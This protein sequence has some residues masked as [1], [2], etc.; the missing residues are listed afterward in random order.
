MLHSRLLRYLDEVAR[1]GSMRGAADRLH[2]ASSAINKHVLR[3]EEAIGEPLFERLPRGLRLTPAGEI[4]IAHVRR[5]LKEYRQ[6]EAG[7]RDLKTLQGGEVIIATMGGL[8]GGIVPKAAATFCARHPQIRI[9]IR[10]MF[11]RDIIQAVTDGEADL[12]LAFNLPPTPQIELLGKVDTRLGAILA[13]EHPLAAMDALT[14][15]L[16]A[17]SP[18]ILADKSMLIH[19]IVVAAFADAG[20]EVE[21]TFLANSIE[22]MKCLAAAGHAIAFLSRVDIAEEQR[23]GLLT[24]RPIRD[25]AMG[26]NVLTLVQREK[27]SPGLATVMFAEEIMRALGAATE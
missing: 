25:V 18:L 4:L 15:P 20:L 26:K 7:I 8:A 19:D 1:C 16:C 17:S 9:S 12:G 24:Y 10:A 22:S 2:V 13:P 21:P 27:R 23:N 5:T 11:I 6:V 3:L 14:L